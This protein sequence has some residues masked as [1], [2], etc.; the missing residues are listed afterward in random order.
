MIQTSVKSKFDAN[1]TTDA[2]KDVPDLVWR[3]YVYLN[4]RKIRF[5]SPG[6]ENK[7]KG[8]RMKFS[9]NTQ[10]Y[11]VNGHS[12]GATSNV[13]SF[14][15][16]GSPNTN[17]SC[18]KHI[19]C[20]LE[21]I[22]FVYHISDFCEHRVMLLPHTLLCLLGFPK[23]CRWRLG[24]FSSRSLEFLCGYWLTSEMIWGS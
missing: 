19:R 13:F 21:A 18:S 15:S 24:W 23:M 5:M 14:E 17:P 16:L 2:F 12:S 6:A 20:V 8:L 3:N 22:G 4:R 11:W 1:S 10:R 7:V 9:S